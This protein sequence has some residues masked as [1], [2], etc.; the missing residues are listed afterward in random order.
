MNGGSPVQRP[1]GF[2]PWEVSA[3]INREVI[4]QHAEEA[5]FLWTQRD[6]A[7]VAPNYSLEDLAKLDRRVEA[8]VDGLRVAGQVGWE[9][10]SEARESGPGEAFAAA[11]LAFESEETQR[12]ESVLEIGSSDPLL[13]RGVVSALGWMPAEQAGPLAMRFSAAEADEIRRIAIA[14]LAIHR[15]DPG[16]GLLKASVDKSSRLRARALKAIGELGKTDMA[17]LLVAGFSDQ[18]D[19]CR[20]MAAWSA[21]RLGVNTT[22]AIEVL[23]AI[24]DAGGPDSQRAL[25]M[26]LRCMPIYEAKAWAAQL[27]GKPE[28]LRLAVIAL[29]IIGDPDAVSE[30]IP[31][32][33]N[34]EVA[35]V[36]GDSFSMI[37]GADLGYEDLDADAPENF[38][39]RPSEDTEDEDVGPDPDED[40]QWPAPDRIAQWWSKR[41]TDFSP[42]VRYLGGKPI[43][44]ES[45][46]EILV[47]GTQRQRAAAALEM[48]LRNPMQPLFEVRERGDRQLERVKRWIS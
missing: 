5:A 10:C 8:H 33:E 3:L 42:G 48:A 17:G 27:G 23:R 12:I 21:A 2:R 29:G 39:E 26:A 7:A 35:R 37:T 40:L 28:T 34:P 13:Q 44:P 47:R 19:P 11:M 1:I 32:M 36:A 9:I 22:A 20:C 24:A 31:L 45:L 43:G 38:A 25:D 46:I 6:S 14:A 41:R 18:D 30:L 15:L 4:E 16:P